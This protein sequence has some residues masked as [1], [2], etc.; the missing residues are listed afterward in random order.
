VPDQDLQR[1]G[2]HV[3]AERELDHRLARLQPSDRGSRCEARMVDRR[4]AVFARAAGLELRERH[5]MAAEVRPE[6]DTDIEGG[7]ALLAACG[8]A[9]PGSGQ[10]GDYENKEQSSRHDHFDAAR[11]AADSAGGW[12][13]TFERAEKLRYRRPVVS[14][15]G[16]GVRDDSLRVDDEVPA[17]LE[18]V[19]AG[20]AK[21]LAA[22][23]LPC[24]AQPD[25]RIAP[26]AG[27]RAAAEPPA[28][29][30]GAVAVDEDRVGNVESAQQRTLEPLPLVEGDK[31]H[32]AEGVDP[33]AVV[34]HL[35][36][37]RAADQ[38]AGVP[39]EDD[40]HGPPAKL[41][42]PVALAGEAGE[43]ERGRQLAD[44]RAGHR[45]SE[46]R[47]RSRTAGTTDGAGSG[48]KCSSSVCRRSIVAR[49]ERATAEQA[50]QPA[51]C[52]RTRSPRIPFSSPSRWSES[53]A[54]VSSHEPTIMSI[55]DFTLSW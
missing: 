45:R 20:T 13:G 50:S 37:V 55:S 33:L 21:A 12:G 7:Q 29:V 30:G 4:D 28:P 11:V 1:V 41:V 9:D 49:S 8:A 22:E 5:Q 43:I 6:A 52:R 48:V 10:A 17:E 32:A 51:R 47:I 3:A 25:A 54:R 14:L 46:W 35:H 31:E 24:V 2:A 18:R 15:L 40:Q 16:A 23:Q 26:D 53:C 38:S 19:A 39:K 42:E 27:D 44:A 36:E 34:E